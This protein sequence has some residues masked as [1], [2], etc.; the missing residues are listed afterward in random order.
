MNVILQMGF[1]SYFLVVADFIMWAKNNGIRVGPGRGSAAGSLV[2]YALG[3]TDLD[4]LPHGLIFERFLNPDRVS[5]PDVDIDF[6]ERRRGDVIR[7]VTEK[8]G[9]EKV[10]MIATFGTIKA[11]AAIKDAARVLGHPYA[12]GDKVSKAFPPAVMGKDI[13]LSGIFDKDHPRFDEAGELRR[14]Y[15]EDADVK[16]AMDL[17]RG[18]EGLIRQTGVH[19]AG[20]IMSAEVL[21]DYVP[22]MRRDSDGVI[23]TQF[24]YPTCE[25]LGLLKMD[26][27][28]LRNLTIIDDCL[29][30][31]KV[32]T[33]RDIDLLDLPLDDA[34]DLRAAGPRRHP[35]RLPARR[36]RHALAAAADA[37]RQLRGHLGGRSRS[38]G[39]AR[40]APTPTPTTR[41]ART[42]SRRSPRSI[43]SWRSRSRRSST[44]PTA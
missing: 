30:A 6:D 9:V 35:G 20:V 8:Y 21:T 36:R 22:I 16:S 7:Y 29:K 3:I 38:T 33:G 27:L 2:A 43:P 26:F 13:P 28:G 12:L 1:P 32:N 34:T 24:D 17:G 14:L 44:R 23:I 25:T 18:L 10:A 37:S 40:W 15:E 39:R 4:P 11:K 41:C 42:A 19:A 5:M 31:I